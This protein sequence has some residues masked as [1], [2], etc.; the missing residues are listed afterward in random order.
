MLTSPKH[1]TLAA[2]FLSSVYLLSYLLNISKE[3]QVRMGQPINYFDGYCVP[4][5][6]S[7]TKVV[8]TNMTDAGIL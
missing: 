6:E 7:R 5:S 8:G 3:K 4:N 2:E 1:A